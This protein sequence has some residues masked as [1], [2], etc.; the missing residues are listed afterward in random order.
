[1]SKN[2]IVTKDI[3]KTY[4]KGSL[5]VHAL[6]KTNIQ[7]V[8]GDYIAISGPSG[9]GKSTFMN[10]LGCLDTPSTGRLYIDD[11][12]VSTLSENQLAKIRREK[13]GFIFQKYNLIPT[14]N[15]LE[16][17]ALSMSF[18][19][20]KTKI[21]IERAKKLLNM[22]DLSKRM[23]HKPSE[24]SGG[25]QQR[26]AISRALANN[27]SIILADEPTGNVDTKSGDKIMSIL[28]NINSQGE[29]VIVVTHDPNIARRARRILRIQ[30]G[31]VSEENA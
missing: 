13:I 7:I 25:E 9:S 23:H 15:A 18:A 27:P 28:E 26:V 11:T 16:N 20:I 17:V 8:Q 4:G 1:M 30:D 29:T 14:L 3:S 24:L 19:G 21:R 12:D 2:V 5:Q 6:R 31:L 10:L 22:V